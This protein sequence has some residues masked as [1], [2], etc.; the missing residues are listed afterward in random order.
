M[1]RHLPFDSRTLK[2]GEE[3]TRILAGEGPEGAPIADEPHI[4]PS[5]S[6]RHPNAMRLGWAAWHPVASGVHGVASAARL[7]GLLPLGMVIVARRYSM[8]GAASE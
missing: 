7:A 2:T 3:A 5:L 6:R 8:R 1:T 4:R